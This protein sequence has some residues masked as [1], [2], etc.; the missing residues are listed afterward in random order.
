MEGHRT[1]DKDN[2]GKLKMAKKYKIKAPNRKVLKK[3]W[4]ALEM[5]EGRH[6][7]EIWGLEKKMAKETV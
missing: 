2:K 1:K 6:S 4:H 5:L 7:K 3:Y